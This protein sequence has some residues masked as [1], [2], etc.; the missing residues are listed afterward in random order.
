MR[1]F[2]AGRGTSPIALA[3]SQISVGALILVVTAP[4]LADQAVDLRL[5]VVASV[6]A[7]GALGT[8]VAYL[9][10]YRLIHDEGP[11]TASTVMY[12]LLIVAVVLGAVVLG[13][14]IT[15]NL[16]AGTAIVLSGVAASSRTRRNGTA[17]T[18]PAVS[19]TVD[20]T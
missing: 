11:T 16:F 14:P 10:N 9:L 6:L 13:E 17:T 18:T 20:L 12:L 19:G 2:L 8:G 4:V 7:L 1:R 5:D 15:W 3:A